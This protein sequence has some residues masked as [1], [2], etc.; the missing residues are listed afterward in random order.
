MFG[1]SLVR[2]E[3]VGVLARFSMS[4]IRLER[5]RRGWTQEELAKKVRR[6][7]TVVVYLEMGRLPRLDVARAVARALEQPI[8]VLW[9]PS[10][11]R[12][13]SPGTQ[14]GAAA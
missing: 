11:R 6:S 8:D 7:T 1:S 4:P 12:K 5:E 13:S 14:D 3:E 10:K 2:Q 9:P